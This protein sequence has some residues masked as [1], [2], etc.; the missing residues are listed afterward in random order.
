M[1]LKN[2]EWTHSLYGMTI[3]ECFI[4][5]NKTGM[6]KVLRNSKAELTIKLN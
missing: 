6:L 4:K 5:L 1:S 3:E 2:L